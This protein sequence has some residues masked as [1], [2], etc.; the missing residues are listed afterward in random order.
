MPKG[1]DLHNHLTGSIYA[2]NWIDYAVQDNL[3]VDR[4]TSNL[5]APPCDESCPNSNKPPVS[6]AYGDQVLYNQLVDAWS[7]R[8]WT[9][10]KGS[11]HD[12]FF[13]TFDKFNLAGANSAGAQLAEVA[14]RAAADRLQYL[15]LMHTADGM[16]AATVGNK[17][18]WDNDFGK[19]RDR[20]LS[21]GLKDVIT[22]TR[23]RLDQDEARKQ[24]IL[25][26]STPH[27]D[28]GCKVTVHYLYQVLR[29]LPREMVFAEILLGFE[30]AHSDPRFVGLNLVMPEDWYVP[31]HDFDLH[32][33]MLDFL[34]KIYPKVHISLHA[35]ELAMG[36]V[37]PEGLRSHIRK[38]IEQG[39]AER[40]GHG[41]SV[42]HEDDPIALLKEM[43]AKNVLVEIC[44]TSNA[45]ILEVEGAS[46]PLPAYLKNKVPVALATDDEGVS[47]SDM[48]QEYLRA[49]QTYGFS[50]A[51]LKQIA[52]QSVEHSF[53]TGE[54]L[55]QA[56][57]RPKAQCASDR[58]GKAKQSP[59]CQK[60]LDASEK[61]KVQWQL[62]KEFSE[63]E[64]SINQ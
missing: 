48:T 29:G 26:C 44:L 41:V 47:R 27:P 51:D 30:L 63:F 7:M 14:S 12:H 1:G 38:S 59:A 45:K 23:T 54:S 11:G 39:H 25:G 52:R 15:E 56:G 3:C 4:A 35:G 16:N 42:M 17:L 55:W 58:P 46:H 49:V 21:N 24:E 2:E 61:A 34:H 62:E 32:M 8:N 28:P 6:C 50:Y 20:L 22:S 37:P 19:M 5:S 64:N 60:L 53:L 57:F 10:A 13:A 9:S 33:Q 18:G 36:L 40:I 43:S 31:M